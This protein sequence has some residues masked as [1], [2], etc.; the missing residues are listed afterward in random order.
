M[1]AFVQATFAGL[2]YALA[3]PE[4]AVDLYVQRHPELKKDLLLAQWKAAAPSMAVPTDGHPAGWQDPAA[5]TT[6]DEWMVTAKLLQSPVDVDDGHQQRLPRRNGVAVR[7]HLAAVP[8][9]DGARAAAVAD[10]ATAGDGGGVARLGRP[11]VRWR[12]SPT[13]R[14]PAGG[15]RP[16]AAYAGPQGDRVVLAG[17]DLRL[18]PGRC[19]A[20]VGESGCGKSTLLHVLAGLLAPRRG[21]VSVDGVRVAAPGVAVPGHAAYLFQQDLL[22]P[23]LSV[24]GNAMFAAR[25]ARPAI[26]GQRRDSRAAPAPCSTSSAWATAW[27]RF[28][29]SS[30]AA[31]VNV[32]L[33]RAPW[34]SVVASCCSTSPSPTSMR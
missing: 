26:G 15:R 22:L 28:P 9:P 3:N 21:T 7:R 33:S 17:L 11:R 1:R 24:L 18:E 2:A 14:R 25:V 16:Q 30:R 5:W 23:W 19:L 31:C 32:S 34:C 10:L 6:L 13:G 12:S 8:G 20:I 29:A 4:E 27:T